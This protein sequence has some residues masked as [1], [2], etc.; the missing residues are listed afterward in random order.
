[1]IKT[2]TCMFSLNLSVMIWRRR[3]V[4]LVVLSGGT[5]HVRLVQERPRISTIG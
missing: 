1:M 5:H 2:V 3:E 4:A